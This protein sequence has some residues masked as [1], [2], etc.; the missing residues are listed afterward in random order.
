MNNLILLILC[1]IAGILLRRFKRIPDNAPATLNSFIIHVSLPA[2]TLLYI[3]QLKLSGDV[4]LVGLMGWLV[5]G[6]SVGCFWLI[7]RWLR[8]L[9]TT[10]GALMLMGGLGNTS[11]FGL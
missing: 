2:L 11:F 7:G 6:L 1:F 3:H 10:V 5:F 4:L 9:R 8:L